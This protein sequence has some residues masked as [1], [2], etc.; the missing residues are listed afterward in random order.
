M[1]GAPEQK[2]VLIEGVLTSYLGPIG[3]ITLNTQLKNL[4]ITREQLGPEDVGLLVEQIG[5]AVTALI[6]DVKGKDVM[7]KMQAALDGTGP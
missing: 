1:N 2:L 4:G 3:P 5:E 6:G 7:D